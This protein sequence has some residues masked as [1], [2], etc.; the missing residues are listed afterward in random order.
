MLENSKMTRR[1]RDR[2]VKRTPEDYQ[3]HKDIHEELRRVAAMKKA[4]GDK[5]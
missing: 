2:N 1:A 4:N 3:S 5:E